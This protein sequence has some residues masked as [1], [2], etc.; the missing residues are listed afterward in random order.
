MG[1]DQKWQ[2][3]FGNRAFRSLGIDQQKLRERECMEKLARRDHLAS[4]GEGREEA[5]APY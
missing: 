1:S 4:G 2:A 5:S 3:V